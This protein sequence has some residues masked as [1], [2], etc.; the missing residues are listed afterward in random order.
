[1]VH[2][3]IT[4]TEADTISV[5]KR[6]QDIHYEYCW[7]ICRIIRRCSYGKNILAYILKITYF[8]QKKQ[9]SVLLQL[10]STALSYFTVLHSAQHWRKIN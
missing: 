8:K 9:N 6:Y 3:S 7:I 5:T 4:N 10:L 2:S 1:V